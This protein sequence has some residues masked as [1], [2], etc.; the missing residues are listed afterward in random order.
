MKLLRAH[1]ILFLIGVTAL[2]LVIG[3]FALKEYSPAQNTPRTIAWG[4]L[5]GTPYYPLSGERAIESNPAEENIY[6]SIQ[7]GPPFYYSTTNSEAADEEDDTFDVDAFLAYLKGETRT[8]ETAVEEEKPLSFL[9]NPYSFIT[10]G[11][12]FPSSSLTKERTPI[13]QALYEYGNKAGKIIQTFE[14]SNQNMADVVQAQSE[15]PEDPLKVAA[16]IKLADSLADVGV[17][18]EELSSVPAEA[19]NQ[20]AKLATSY[21]D[22]GAKLALVP[23]AMT[24]DSRVETML[25]YNAAAESFVTNYVAIVTLFSIMEVTFSP[26]EPGSVFTF[27]MTGF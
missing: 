1:F 2:L 24:E 23:N 5:G 18:L 14:D 16:L 10:N 17:S 3:A 26:D 12:S 21:K 20:N 19:A 9:E 25:T 11:V 8:S 13:Q 27:T 15:D 7:S 4:G 6:S 22:M